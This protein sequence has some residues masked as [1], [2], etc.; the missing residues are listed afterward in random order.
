M[1]TGEPLT[2]V[3]GQLIVPLPIRSSA[4]HS[5]WKGDGWKLLLTGSLTVAQMACGVGEQQRG[6]DQVEWSL[7]DY[8]WR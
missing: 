1:N 2:E 3:G 4:A 8:W 6:R 7:L 5:A